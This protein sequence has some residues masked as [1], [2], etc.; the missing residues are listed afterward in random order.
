MEKD[1]AKLK[2][3]IYA[4]KSS[5]SDEKQ[6]QSIGDQIEICKSLSND[7]KL[8]V[9]D[10]LFEAKSA[11]EPGNRPKFLDLINRIKAGE[12]NGVICWKIDRLSRNP[13]DSAEIQWL[14]QQEIIKSIQTPGR[15]YISEDNVLIFSVESSMANQFIR[16]LSKNVK[17][18]LKSKI[19]KG[20]RPGVAPLGWLNTKIEA[21][22]ENYIVKDQERF[23]LLRKCWDL[24]LTGNYVPTEILDKLN[25]EWG[26]RTR[27]GKIRGGKPMSRSTIYHMFTNPFFAGLIEKES[28]W[29]KGEHEPM[30]TLEE[31]DK[32][33]TLLGRDGKPRPNRYKYSYT[34]LIRCGECGG[35]ISATFK[36]KVLKSAGE[37]KQYSLYYCVCSRNKRK[38]CS[39]KGYVNSE[40]IEE[41]IDQELAKL[42]IL[43]EFK[44]WALEILSERNENEVEKRQKVY[45]SQQKTLRDLRKQLDNLTQALVKELVDED[46]YK[47]EKAR[48]Q[49]EIAKIEQS[50]KETENNQDNWIEMTEGVFDFTCHAR[51]HFINGSVEDKK[52]ILSKIGVN[53]TLKDKKLSIDKH[54]WLV[55]IEKTYP[56]LEKEFL[57]CELDKK[58][59]N[60][61]QK[62]AF[63]LLRPNMRE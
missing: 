62:E 9:V 13:I 25:N 19:D 29:E 47:R 8:K 16:D 40:I 59:Y 26:F 34:G 45:Q 23:P 51:E 17:R 7:Y 20:W 36:E 63:D 4:R 2:Y 50:I 12:A 35:V 42:T 48:I 52:T 43:P 46:S 55:A 10:I 21:R 41:Q 57:L 56:E 31:F 54:P 11:K 33:Q 18:G 39:Q 6:I 15:E 53:C 22:G 49:K 5:E 38:P 44:D 60:K 37:L 28:G 58:P 30:V 14:L 1:R 27:K 61:R 3:L 24:M 32:V